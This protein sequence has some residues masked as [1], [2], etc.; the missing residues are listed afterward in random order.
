MV[1]QTGSD[2]I[3]SQH[4][5]FIRKRFGFLENTKINMDQITQITLK[6][7]SKKSCQDLHR[8]FVLVIQ[9]KLVWLY[10]NAAWIWTWKKINN[11][12]FLLP[13]SK[14]L[15]FLIE[16]FCKSTP[17]NNWLNKTTLHFS[18]IFFISFSDQE[19]LTIRQ[20]A[21]HQN[22]VQTLSQPW[23]KKPSRTWNSKLQT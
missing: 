18:R 23:G 1:D 8:I 2:R 11:M 14:R 15:F 12:H 4:F 10:L 21:L 22:S 5:D 16:T 20:R 13:T 19:C 7:D 3:L 6:M 9:V 17:N